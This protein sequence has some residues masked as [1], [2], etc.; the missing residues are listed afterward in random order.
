MF[1]PSTASITVK[2][3]EFV[4]GSATN[5]TRRAYIFLNRGCTADGYVKHVNEFRRIGAIKNWP[6]M[7]IGKETADVFYKVSQY[8]VLSRIIWLGMICCE[9]T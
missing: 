2:N 8:Y 4:I 7:M 9:M 3:G 1:L 5:A 6:I